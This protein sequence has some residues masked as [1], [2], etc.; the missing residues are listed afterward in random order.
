[1][2]DAKP[3]A[4]EGRSAFLQRLPPEAVSN[5]LFPM[6]TCVR[7]DNKNSASCHYSSDLRLPDRQ[8]SRLTPISLVH[9]SQLSHNHTTSPWAQHLNPESNQNRGLKLR[10]LNHERYRKLQAGTLTL[11][12]LT[13]HFIHFPDPS[14]PQ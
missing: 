10:S 2:T 8:Q 3:L 6:R 13:Y 11:T 5:E 4:I 12:F 14:A 9:L 1:M 7:C